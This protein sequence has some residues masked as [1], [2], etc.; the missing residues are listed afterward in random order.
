MV[1]VSSESSSSPTVFPLVSCE[2]PLSDANVVAMGCLARDFLPSSISFSWNYQN[3]TKV[4][5]GV[6]TFPTMRA[7]NK[8][9]ATSQ[10]L[11]SPKNVLEG[12]DEY[13]VCKVHHNSK[14]KDLLVPLPVV[15]TINPNVTVFIPPRDAFSDPA[16]RKSRLICEASNFSPKQITVSWLH[17]G[18]PVKSGFTTGPVTAEDKES[19]PRTYKVISTLTITESDWLNMNVYSCRVD[20]S[21]L[22]FWKNVSSTCAASPST[23]ILAFPIPPSFVD[24]FLSKSA[25]L[26]CLVT[27]LATYD[28]L[29]ISW[30]TESGEPLETNLEL[31]ESHPNGTFSAKGV[32]NVCVEDWDNS[33][34]FVCTVTHRD[35]PSPQKK[36]ISK[37]MNVAK[38]PPAVYMLPPAREQLILRESATITCLV[39]GFS[40]S[41]IF[42]QWLQRGQP[43]SSDKYVTSAPMPEPQTPDLY[44]IHSILTVTEEEWNSGE[45]YTCV[46][47]HEAL[48]HMVTERTVDKSTEGEVNA[49]EEGFENLWTTAST[50]IVLFLLSLFYSTT[51]TL[52]KDSIVCL[53]ASD[54]VPQVFL[55]ISMC[56]AV[57]KNVPVD[58]IC[59]VIGKRPRKITWESTANNK[60]ERAFPIQ[61][62]IGN[63]IMSHQLSLSTSELNRTHTCIIENKPENIKKVFQLPETWNDQ[64]SQKS[65]QPPP[66]KN[67]VA[68]ATTVFETKRNII[69]TRNDQP[70]QKSPLPSLKKN[71]VT[72]A[73]KAFDTK[74]NIIGA[75]A[76]TNLSVN[77]L[78]ISTHPEMSSWLMCEVSGFSPQDIHLI[79][80]EFQNEMHSSYSATAQ[81]IPQPGGNT[82]QTWSV[83]RIP[84]TQRS[85]LNTYTC[86]VEH[87]A[88]KTKLNASQSLDICGM[89]NTIPNLCIRDEQSD[90]YVELDEENG[91]W[92]TVCTFLALFLLTLLYSGFVTFIKVK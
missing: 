50:F 59:L 76:P 89:V 75:T 71:Q 45:T 3:N 41:D 17:D 29:N 67:Q 73:T 64:P 83:L 32:A 91:L 92:P 27:N 56:K 47:G 54:N 82:F 9:M 20:H 15:T 21:G 31:T 55:L 33:K 65:P 51:V 86:V 63:Y 4:E 5:K 35:L 74:R 22:T 77:F 26:T 68:E 13:L 25:K 18:K 88:S 10:V 30:A 85:S 81:P 28:T 46:V 80:L 42:V 52:F 39:K 34:K 11:L 61:K 44:F 12:S 6:R 53:A 84:A 43:L 40:P 48:P 90:S 49:E 78:A 2:S 79:W 37:P 58:L 16:P 19:G 8:Y 70:S 69:E 7:G 23:D 66:K 1:T 38:H 14:N 87:E 36:V 72:E 60:T 24:I 62:N 57:N